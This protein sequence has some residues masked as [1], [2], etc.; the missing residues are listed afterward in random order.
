VRQKAGVV[1]KMGLRVAGVRDCG[2]VRAVQC[3]VTQSAHVREKGGGGRRDS[4]VVGGARVFAVERCGRVLC[5]TECT[6]ERA[7]VERVGRHVLVHA[8]VIAESAAVTHIGGWGVERVGS[9][10]SRASCG[11]RCWFTAGS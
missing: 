11:A 2:R 5:G 1:W 10:H 4:G 6:R 8:A 3:R 9:E 7:E